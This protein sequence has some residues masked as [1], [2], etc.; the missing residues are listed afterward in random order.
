MSDAANID[1]EKQGR[2]AATT[3]SAHSEAREELYVRQE[4]DSSEDVEKRGLERQPSTRFAPQQAPV[5]RGADGEEV[6]A[7]PTRTFS[8]RAARDASDAA[9][10]FGGDL[11][12]SRTEMT[13]ERFKSQ[14]GKVMA[15]EPVVVHWEGDDD[16]ENP[17][18]FSKWYKIYLTLF[19]ALLVLNSTFTSSCPSGIVPMMI[20]YFQFSEEVATLTISLWVAGYCLGPLIWG[21]LSERLGRKPVFVV[22]VFMYTIW[23]MGC[24]LAKNT[25]SILVFRFLGGVFGAAPLTN[26]GGIIADVWDAK[27][28]GIALSFFSIAPFAGPAIGPIVSG[29][30]QVRMASWRYVYWT[31]MAF[32][33]VCLL[34]VIF[35][36][37][38][39]YAPTILTRKAKRIRKETG[40]DFYK[41][42]LELTPLD[43]KHLLHD[44]LLFPFVML[45]QEPIRELAR[46]C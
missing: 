31:C 10:P 21:P 25:A 8:R 45:F 35:T 27:A 37:R 40:Q 34:L 3:P 15:G 44:T 43:P 30:I 38:E 46:S 39:T 7:K 11:S 1:L 14:K 16:P 20:N 29:A 23:N 13:L 24:A 36:V 9:T 22:S 6:T 5:Y 12:I 4:T 18:N 42:P 2:D 26:S 17:Q 28:R 19:G 41:S 33:G 32:S